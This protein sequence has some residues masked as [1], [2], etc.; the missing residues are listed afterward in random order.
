MASQLSPWRFRALHTLVGALFILVVYQLIQLCVIRRFSLLEQAEKQQNLKIEI[1]AFRGTILDRHG[2]ELAT[3]LKVPS[4]YAIP[5]LL[6]EE[7]KKQLA[8]SLS[9]ILSVKEALIL[10]RLKKDK[11]FVWLKRRVS[12]EE[13]EKIRN[14]GNPA[15]AL[16]E[17][18]KRFYPQGDLLSHVL[19]FV[20]V[21]NRGME[22]I[23][24]AL[25]RELEGQPGR[26]YTK[27]DALGREV[28]AFEVKS[29][30]AI[31]GK[32]VYLTI[33]QYLQY[34]TERALDRAY[35]TWHAK[36]AAAVMMEARTGRIL[37]MANR[38]AYDPNKPGESLAESRRNRVVTDMY[39]PGS[40]F[41]V[42]AFSGV[43]NEGKA[44]LEDKFFCEN[45]HYHYYGGR[46]LHD[47]HPYGTLTLPEI[48]IKSSNIGSV[49]VAALLDQNTF[50]HYIQS[51]GFGQLTGIDMPGEAG[52]VIRPPAEWSKTSPYNIPIG[53]EVSVTLLQMARAFAV[54]ANGGEL[55]TPY[56]ISKIE[57]DAGVTLYEKKPVIRARAIREETA[58]TLRDMMVQVVEVGTG[59]KARIEGVPVAGKTGTAQKVLPGGRGYSHDK[60]MSSFIGFAPADDAKVVMAVMLDDPHPSYYGGTVAAPVFKESIEAAL[61]TM[62]YVPKNASIFNGAEKEKILKSAELE[63]AL[64]RKIVKAKSPRHR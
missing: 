42:V 44:K 23:E 62:G 9:K 3:S 19:G 35:K 32:R 16:L 13:A 61:Y 22:G 60:F 14:F 64:K 37:A 57:D 52:G 10:K 15:V 20:N 12:F 24:K 56:V 55:V 53:H 1:P 39:E 63:P 6:S 47:A 58:H 21:D 51:F 54:I 31:N 11:S 29:V 48:L 36:G 5:R 8:E 50:F 34:V 28:K 7:E 38:P 33:D 4:I 43:I 17:E 18:Y 30:P 27:R 26:R 59:T 45:G 40:I 49:K 2:K 41:K 46:I 25:N